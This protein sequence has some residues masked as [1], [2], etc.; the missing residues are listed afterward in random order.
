MRSADVEETA[1]LRLRENGKWIVLLCILC[2]AVWG[3]TLGHGFV[4]DDEF[5]VTSNPVLRDWRYLPQ[6]FTD[7]E[8]MAGQGRAGEFAV[9]RPLRNISYLLDFSIAGLT[10]AWWHAHNLLLHLANSIMLFIL[11]RRLLGSTF[12]AWAAAA[13][14]LVHPVQS[15]VVAW[16]KC[17]DDLLATAAVLGCFLA[18]SSRRSAKARSGGPAIVV[19]LLYACACLAKIQAVALPLAVAAYFGWRGVSSGRESP[20]VRAYR[21][22]GASGWAGLAAVGIVCLA[23]RHVF[24]GHS[25]QGAY[26]AGSFLDTMLTMIRAAGAYVR[27]LVWPHPL[28]ADYSGMEPSVSLADLRVWVAMAVLAV[29]ALLAVA[30]RKRAPVATL[31]ICWLGAFLLPVSNVVPMVQYMA[32]RFLYLPVA[33]AALA[34][35]ACIALAE[36]RRTAWLR[37]LVAVVIAALGIAGAL[38][39]GVWESSETLF[40][41]TV[42]DTPARA[43]RPR[44]NL[45]A[46]LINREKWSEALPLAVELKRVSDGGTVSARHAAEYAR[47]LGYLHLRQGRRDEG[48]A[49]LEEALA[50]APLYAQPHV[51]LGMLAGLEGRHDEAQSRFAEAV[52]MDPTNGGAWYNLGL[53]LQLMNR[54]EEAE[55]AFQAAI[56]RDGGNTQAYKALAALLW[57]QG[58]FDEVVGVYRDALRIAPEETEL[59]RW[60]EKAESKR[61]GLSDGPKRRHNRGQ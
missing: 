55:D 26:L 28:V 38:R 6:Y 45:L 31:G 10:P 4:W 54:N 19:G 61:T 18:L 7:V 24:L 14:F 15:E 49:L 37:P 48:I 39:A 50:R 33:G 16:V 41:V 11:G 3:R 29:P 40:R 57:R 13:L 34:F 47:H 58:R 59:R 1:V 56:C 42:R 25:E 51:D 12:A 22:L 23:W 17:R 30:M 35:G 8:T 9:F 53:S 21:G 20:W 32:E 52:A 43:I 36:R 2:L 44:R 60:L 27:L 5:F 46:E